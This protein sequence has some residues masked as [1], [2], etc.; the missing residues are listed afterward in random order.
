MK[1]LCVALFLVAHL[2]EARPTKPKLWPPA[3]EALQ[4]SGLFLV[5]GD[6]VA[7]PLT[8][9]AK[10]IPFL[11]T[12]AK[13]IDVV[14]ASSTGEALLAIDGDV[15]RLRGLELSPVGLA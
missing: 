3:A 7:L 13:R 5:A 12:P 11:A 9:G 14:A 6:N 1:T 15:Y 10:P 8:A 2:A 4:K